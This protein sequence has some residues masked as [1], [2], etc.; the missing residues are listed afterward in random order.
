M[1]VERVEIPED[2]PAVQGEVNRYQATI[3]LARTMRAELHA[4]GFEVEELYPSRQAVDI[5]QINQP[6]IW[7]WNIKAPGTVAS[8]NLVLQIYLGDDPQPSWV[9]SFKVDVSGTPEP[10]A[11]SPLLLGIVIAVLV[12]GNGLLGL[13]LFRLLR[14]RPPGVLRPRHSYDLAVL[15]ELLLTAFGP[16]ELRRL[17]QDDPR[18]RPILDDLDA[19]PSLNEVVDATIVYC[20]RHAL[21]ETLLTNVQTGNAAQYARFES[22]LRQTGQKIER[23]ST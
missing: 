15:R 6:T 1:S 9:R 19:D 4:L 22:R 23:G 11:V 5:D 14:K 17:C 21:F 7:A 16:S 18:L 10:P 20:E 2:A 3:K 13:A 8:H 12:L